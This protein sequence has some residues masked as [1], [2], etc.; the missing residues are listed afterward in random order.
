MIWALMLGFASIDPT[1]VVVDKC[2]PYT[3]GYVQDSVVHICPD[4]SIPREEVENHEIVHLI[5]DNLGGNIFPQ[6]VLDSLVS[7]NISERELLAVISVYPEDE[8]AGELEAEHKLSIRSYVLLYRFSETTW[9]IL[10]ASTNLFSCQGRWCSDECL[11]K[12]ELIRN[13][14]AWYHDSVLE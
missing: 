12:S 14:L 9:P 7:T 8:V 11:A 5:Q 2:P 1:I 10:I 13:C 6:E 3:Q 4:L